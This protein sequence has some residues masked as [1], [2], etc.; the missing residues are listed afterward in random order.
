[1]GLRKY[2]RYKNEGK[3]NKMQISRNKMK[4]STSKTIATMFALVMIIS[5]G[6]SVIPVDAHSPAWTI[7]TN[8]YITATPNPVG[9]GQMITLVVWLDQ[10]P[11]TAA[12]TAGDRWAGNKIDVTKP[13]GSKET[14]GPFVL[15]SATANDWVT[16]VPD[17][18][19]T[20]TFVYSWPGQTLKATNDAG[21][22]TGGIPYIG[23][24]FAGSTSNPVTVVVG[25][26]AETEWV[27]PPIPTDYWSMPIHDANRAWSVLASNWLKG[28][29][30]VNNEQYGQSPASPH[31]LWTKP[32]TPARAGGINDAAWPGIP[33]NKDDYESPWTAPIIMNGVIYYNSPPVADSQKYGYYA[34]DLYT[35]EQ[36]WYKNG[37]DNGINVPAGTTRYSGIGGAGVYSGQT[38][39]GLT[40]GQLYHYNAVNGQG[41]VAYLWM[42]SGSTWYMMD[43]AT[44]NWIMTLTNVPSGTAVTDQ[45]GSLLRYSYNANTGALLCWNSSQSIPPASPTGTGQ[46][47]WKPMAGA[48]IDAV[49]DTTWTQ[50][51]TAQSGG[52]FDSSDIF[53]RSGYTMNLTVQKGLPGI[54]NVLQDGDRV[55]KM[56]FGADI[57]N[58]GQ[59][60]GASP[61]EDVFE[62]YAMT[63]N[64]HATGYTPYANKTNTQ[65]TNLGFT[66]TLLWTKNITVPVTGKNYTWSIGGA[67]Y[68]AKI[69]VVSCKQ[70]MQKWGYSLDT[71]NL[72]W[73]PTAPEGAMN[74]YGMGQNTYYGKYMLSAGY[75]GTLYCYDPL[76]GDLMWTYNATSVGPESPYGENYPIS[77]TF[78]ADGKVF[79]HST[80]HSPTKPLWRGSYLRCINITDGTEMWKLLD[81]NMGAGI[82]SGYIVTGNL[83]DNNI[84]CIGKGPSKLTVQAPMTGITAGNSVVISGTVTDQ[85]PGAKGTPAIADVNMQAW[86]EY[87]YEQQAMPTN[88][89]GVPV[90]ID[91]V[92]PNGNFVNIGSVTSD[93]SGNFGFEWK[94]PDVP[95]K[96]TIIATFAGSNS[97]GSS[98]AETYA[99]VSDAPATP[100]P[101]AAPV[102]STADLYFVPAIAGLF[103]AIIVVGLLIIL[104]L[105]KRA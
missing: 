19:G 65:N 51:G 50:W 29:W 64:E 37:T 82:A 92:D 9:V 93:L 78:V 4:L 81:F 42:V 99:V 32:L 59:G 15:R 85:S 52:F 88:A 8:A 26:T 90:T 48:T 63:I 18:V 84:Y 97:Y 75:S 58:T 102:E 57:A 23:D 44:G 45:D 30:L 5:M 6:A 77:I 13:D 46:Q 49:N 60:L 86:M 38:F 11:P 79:L 74:Y 31:I 91:A 96:Y 53:P 61:T 69:F 41:I 21:I 83:Y 70:T 76:T 22:R 103:V 98:Y 43:A 12:G 73:G 39:T 68:D 36:L 14:I 72:L 20:Y 104:V 56:L 67:N 28:S 24:F 1:V 7:P 89:N 34:M 27:E 35:G 55:P 66:T 33:S 101:T 95:G 87:L 94:T 3:K 40:Q 80:E 54:S 10:N 16:Y 71:G 25:Q 2:F 17:Q 100:A 62:A 47:Q 105:R